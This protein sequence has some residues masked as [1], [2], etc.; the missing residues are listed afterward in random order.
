MIF[1]VYYKYTI[2]ESVYL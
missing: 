1:N 2:I